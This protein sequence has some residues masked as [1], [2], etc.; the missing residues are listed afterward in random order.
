MKKIQTNINGL[1]II[2]NE[3]FS[4]ERGQFMEIWNHTNFQNQNLNINFSQ[5]NISI[6]RKNVIRGLHF[7]NQPYGQIKYISVIRGKVLDVVVDIRK[8]SKTFGEYFT[9]EL[10]NN[11]TGLLVPSGMAHGFLSLEDNTIFSYKCSGPYNPKNEHTI[12]W[13]DKD[14]GIPWG[15]MNPIISKKDNNGISLQKYITSNE[16]NA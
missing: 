4:D 11:N 14:I 3:I 5:D 15:I 10:K 2:K 16:I 9:I 8:E 1:F 13:N 6:S 12:K 7:Q